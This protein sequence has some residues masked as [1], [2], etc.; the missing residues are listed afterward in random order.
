[1]KKFESELASIF[2]AYRED[3]GT[4]G[5]MDELFPGASIGEIV[6]DMYNA[7]LIPDDVLE[8]FLND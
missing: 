5:L 3:H 7:G 4:D 1:M 6:V 2:D 8:R